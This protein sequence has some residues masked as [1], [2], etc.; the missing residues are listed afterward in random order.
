MIFF[1]FCVNITIVCLKGGIIL[2]ESLKPERVF[3]YFEEI[4]KIP[5]GSGN[6]KA[7]SDYCVE[8]AKE[9]GLS[10]IQDDWNN[11]IIIKEASIGR[12]QDA[13]IVLQG[14]LDMVT[15]K[16]EG[17]A[18]DFTKDALRLRIE[19]DDI[20]AEGTSLG[21]DDGIAVAYALAVLED[22]SLS[23]PRLEVVL[24]VDEEIGLLGATGIDLSMLK[25]QYL[26]NL[27][28]EE[29]GIFLTSCAGGLRGDCMIPVTY[30]EGEGVSY[31]VK[32]TGLTGGH[33]GSE[34]DKERANAIKLL[35]RLLYRLDQEIS[36]GI[37]ALQGGEKDNAIAVE[38]EI[39]LLVEAQDTKRFT[40]LLQACT[41]IY[42][43][44]YAISDPNLRIEMVEK[45]A[46]TAKQ[47]SPSCQRKVVYLL[48][49]LPNGV[50]NRSLNIPGLVETSLNLGMI[51]LDQENLTVTASIRSS[52]GTR[53]EAISDQLCYM[54]EFLGGTYH[55][56][57]DYPAW[58]YRAD[59][60]LRE[61]MVEI[62]KKKYGKEPLVQAIHAGL[63]CGILLEKCP[64][65]DAISFGPNIKDIH[66]TRERLSIS[67]TARVWEYLIEVLAKLS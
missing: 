49:T 47:L 25:G 19:G 22:H 7:I 6:T 42:Q 36:Y 32:V 8:F 4:S 33:S 63:E 66:T 40:A 31:Q 29:E 64:Q 30:T 38:C 13:G 50:Q 35:G 57:G 54:T 12:E 58:E 53:K 27:D 44:E 59:S 10:Y 5:H 65:L 3:Y 67:S 62:Y 39:C 34:I 20:Y 56:R 14:H 55:T 48:A 61:V 11:V 18:I 51:N 37:C 16:E 24:T 15:V 2:L 21:G 45:G 28:S 41:A 23:H 26:L 52:V 43:A 1:V 46:C 9:H 17:C 60:K